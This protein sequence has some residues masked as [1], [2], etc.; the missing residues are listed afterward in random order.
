MLTQ[1]ELKE[2]LSYDSETGV[3]TWLQ[4]RGGKARKGS[5]AG[6]IHIAKEA[7]YKRVVIGV[8]GGKHIAARLAHLYMVGVFPSGEMDH[9]NGDTLNNCWSNLRDVTHGQNAVNRHANLPKGTYYMPERYPNHPWYTSICHKGEV[10]FLG[11]FETEEEAHAV[12]VDEHLKLN[13]EHSVF[14]LQ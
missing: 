10:K 13:G 7:G 1:N 14:H 6:T 5:I 9:K 2:L 3:F 8:L 11:C 4:H 12:F